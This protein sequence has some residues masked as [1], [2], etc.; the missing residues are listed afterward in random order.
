MAVVN[1]LWRMLLLA[2]LIG[3][4]TAIP[5]CG[6]ETRSV[7]TREPLRAGNESA[8]SQ[9]QETQDT[10]A[11]PSSENG[12]GTP[13]GHPAGGGPTAPQ[14]ASTALPEGVSPALA[15]DAQMYAEQFGV[16]LSE[17][18]TRLT[19]QEPIGVLG[20]E[21]EAREA[22][23]L[24]GLWIQNEPEYRVVV[25]FTR[26]GESTIGKYVQDG[27]LADIIEVR[28]ADA[29]LRDLIQAQSKASQIVAGVGFQLSSGINVIENRVEI[30]T[31]DRAQLEEALRE[32]GKTL[33]AHVQIVGP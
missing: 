15:R 28:T 5:G 4:M 12:S 2:G 25:A 17:A 26:D 19:L 22:D 30:Y 20:A 32:G 3:S 10:G 29:T 18:I 21:L 16:D 1:H 11:S 33:P 7:V 6:D 24:A 8:V 31:S 13:V 9:V 14:T 27:P 23:T